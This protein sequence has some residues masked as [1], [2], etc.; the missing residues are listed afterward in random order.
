MEK[1][2]VINSK[3]EVPRTQSSEKK[4]KWLKFVIIASIVLIV[5]S[6]ITS[7]FNYQV[8]KLLILSLA[9]YVYYKNQVAD[10]GGTVF[11]TVEATLKSDELILGY[12]KVDRRDGMGER[13]EVIIF[14]YQK[15]YGLEYCQELLSLRIAGKPIIQAQ[16]ENQKKYPGTRIFANGD[17]TRVHILY[18]D[19]ANAKEFIENLTELSGLKI[20]YKERF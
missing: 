20:E 14:P 2:Y 8:L 1:N 11:T 18:L 19:T 15:I 9:F 4:L 10:Q 17:D 3:V 7:D 6:F 12:I 5:F 13:K 16:C